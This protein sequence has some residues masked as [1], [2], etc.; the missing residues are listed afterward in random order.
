MLVILV[1]LAHSQGLRHSRVSF[2]EMGLFILVRMLTEAFLSPDSIVHSKASWSLS[3]EL[4]FCS[5]VEAQTC[6][7]GLF[8][9][10]S[11]MHEHM[12]SQMLQEDF[13]LSLYFFFNAFSFYEVIVQITNDVLMQSSIILFFEVS[14]T[15]VSFEGLNC[16]CVSHRCGNS[17]GV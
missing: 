8:Y 14:L 2:F 4:H 13:L 16:M 1:S 17:R 7:S 9:K 10:H 11:D 6:M 15:D 12:H 3:H 5:V